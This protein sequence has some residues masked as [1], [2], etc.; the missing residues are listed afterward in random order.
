MEDCVFCKIIAGEIPCHKIYEDDQVIAI[1]DH[2]PVRPGHCMVLPKEHIDY[3]TNLTDELSAHIVSVGNRLG[4]A[5]ME[6]MKPRPMRIG[7]VVHG[8][9]PHVHYHVIP[10]HSEDDITSGVYATIR[11]QKVQFDAE[12]VP[13]ADNNE[14]QKI[15]DTLRSNISKEAA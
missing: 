4:R 5:I 15:A 13:I 6:E 10:Q 12:L 11:E 1:L 2:R 7:F 9:I 14:Q 3:F 8:Y